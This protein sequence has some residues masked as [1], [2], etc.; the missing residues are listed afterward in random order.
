MTR[1]RNFG[2]LHASNLEEHGNKVFPPLP[3]R[4]DLFLLALKWLGWA[5]HH[6]S[7]NHWK[8]PSP[9]GFAGRERVLE[10]VKHYK[11]PSII[12]TTPKL[13]S[14]VVELFSTN[15]QMYDKEFDVSGLLDGW[16]RHFRE[17]EECLGGLARF[18]HA[19]AVGEMTEADFMKESAA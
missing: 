11:I 12:Y 13:W 6:A 19:L 2:E 16:A 9:D 4:A 1:N 8:Q 5:S 18:L 7:V 15:P 17:P 10:I 14:E 3:I